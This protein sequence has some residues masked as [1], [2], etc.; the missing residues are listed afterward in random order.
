MLGSKLGRGRNDSEKFIKLEN[1]KRFLSSTDIKESAESYL[2]NQK[3]LKSPFSLSPSKYN[4]TK[5]SVILKRNLY[6]L[7]KL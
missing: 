2:H 1:S 7:D 3:M 5:P 6:K 4:Q